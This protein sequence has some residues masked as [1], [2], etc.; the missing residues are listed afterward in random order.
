MRTALVFKN[1]GKRGKE[2]K[3]KRPP[4]HHGVTGITG[5]TTRRLTGGKISSPSQPYYLSL[6]L[7]PTQGSNNKKG[8]KSKSTLY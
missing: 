6:V 8:L 5:V 2:G 7:Y 3:L 4:H 1:K